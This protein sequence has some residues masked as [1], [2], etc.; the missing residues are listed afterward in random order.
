[1]WLYNFIPH[2]IH[3]SLMEFQLHL[4]IQLI[5]LDQVFFSQKHI[6]RFLC[7]HKTMLVLLGK[8]LH[9]KTEEPLT[10]ITTTYKTVKATVHMK[11]MNAYFLYR[12]DILYVTDEQHW[13][14]L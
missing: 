13:F 6:R 14:Y 8:R 4:I 7:I 1:M 3:V 10:A 5:P 12:V 9:H 11:H 2:S